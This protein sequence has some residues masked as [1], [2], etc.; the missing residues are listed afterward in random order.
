MRV[1]E[2]LLREALKFRLP[3]GPLVGGDVDCLKLKEE[4]LVVNV[5]GFSAKGVMLPFMNLR[6][7]GWRGAI[8]SFSDLI[9]KGVRPIGAVF[10]VYG[11]NFEAV[12]EISTGVFEALKEYEVIFLG[13][14]TNKG[15]EAIDVTSFGFSDYVPKISNAK[16]GNLVIVPKACWGCIN[17]C[18]RGEVIDHCKRPKPK[19]EWA[20]VISSF[21]DKITASTDS[22]DG[23]AI[24]LYRIAKASG[25]K[26]VLH[27]LPP[28]PFDEDDV[29]YGGEE[30]APILVVESEVAEEVTKAIDG[31]I[32]GKVERGDGV[33]YKGRRLEE[34]GWEWF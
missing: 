24:S 6:D 10:S 11:K 29:L 33:W 3:T 17:A 14:D 30:Y 7:V 32:I 31:F 9:A 25:V 27:D 5:D 28:S 15:E 22:S 19:L 16:P 8:A 26:I 34:R 18:L 13:A 20:K 4:C 12:K 23:L 1:E 2:A 21:R